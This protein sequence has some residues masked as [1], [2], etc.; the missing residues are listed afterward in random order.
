M[1]LL[2]NWLLR[3]E[4]D[5][6]HIKMFNFAGIKCRFKSSCPGSRLLFSM[7]GFNR[8]Q[9]EIMWIMK[10]L[11]SK[12]HIWSACAKN[13][14]YKLYYSACRTPALRILSSREVRQQSHNRAEVWK[15]GG[16]AALIG[17]LICCCTCSG[18]AMAISEIDY[19]SL[20]RRRI[21]AF[22]RSAAREGPEVTSVHGP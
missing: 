4:F 19:P 6:C 9:Y 22:Y 18:S 11:L 21:L 16:F 8:L 20:I 12:L 3:R 15:F 17:W 7:S 5:W 1:G 14:I 13:V 10:A 2:S